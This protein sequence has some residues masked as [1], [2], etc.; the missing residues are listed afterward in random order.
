[1]ARCGDASAGS[2]EGHE[3]GPR[4]DLGAALR[5]LPTPE[6]RA[7]FWQELDDQLAPPGGRGHR[8]RQRI[9]GPHHSRSRA[10]LGLLAMA[11]AVLVLVGAVAVLRRDDART[12]LATA[13]PTSTTT[14]SPDERSYEPGPEQ[15]LGRGMVAGISADGSAALVAAEDPEAGETGCEGMPADLLFAAPL[16]GSARRRAIPGSE[17]VSGA[18][19]RGPDPSRLAIVS[20]CEEFLSGVHVATEQAGGILVDVAPIDPRAVG[21]LVSRLSWSSDGRSLLGV[22]SGTW[23]VVRVDVATGRRETV[24][25]DADSLQAAEL[26]DGTLVALSRS[27][28]LRVGAEEHDVPAFGIAVSPDGRQVAAHGEGGLFLVASGGSPRRVATGPVGAVAWASDGAA[29]AYVGGGALRV[30]TTDGTVTE[31]LPSGAVTPGF[32]T[33]DGSALVFTRTV[34]AAGGDELVVRMVRFG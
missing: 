7:G 20:A 27:S 23:D 26:A 24:L 12:R 11:A 17:P 13:P 9:S 18:I 30:V 5:D 16:D 4:S 33:P 10:G 3:R 25:A 22:V 31:I 19:L 15:D 32:F 29:L 2:E 21:D 34:P 1:M 28:T 14:T 8:T 6:H